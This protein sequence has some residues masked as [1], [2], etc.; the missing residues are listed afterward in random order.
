MFSEGGEVPVKYTCRGRDI[1]HPLEIKETPESALSLALIMDDPDAPGGTWTHWLVWNIAPTTTEIAENSVPPEATQG[2]N[3]AGKTA[4]HGPCPPSGIHRYF[5][6]L[7]AL[8][9]RLDLASGSARE[10]LEKAMA[11][12]ILDQAVYMGRFGS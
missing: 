7:Y 10:E 4:Y 3:T 5:F 2:A 8:D 6:T 11:G 1:N 9:V 12:H